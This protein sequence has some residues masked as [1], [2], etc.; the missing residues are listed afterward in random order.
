MDAEFFEDG[1]GVAREESDD[2]E[3]ELALDLHYGLG[4]K[5]KRRRYVR[6]VGEVV[7][8]QGEK[9]L[10]Q[11]IQDAEPFLGRRLVAGNVALGSTLHPSRYDQSK[12]S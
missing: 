8:Q 12:Q 6:E 5:R 7:E 9:R 10:L 11:T 4:S 3:A 1:F 2:G